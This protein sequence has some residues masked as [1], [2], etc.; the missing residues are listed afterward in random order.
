MEETMKKVVFSALAVL[1]AL[2][3]MSCDIVGTG[4]LTPGAPAGFDGVIYSDGLT[5]S[6]IAPLYWNG[7]NGFD[8]GDYSTDTQSG[9]SAFYVDWSAVADWNGLALNVADTA[10][11]DLSGYDALTFYAKTESG[12][13]TFDKFGIAAGS[14]EE[15][16]LLNQTVTSTWTKYILPLPNPS[17]FN[18]VENIFFTAD[19]AGDKV[20]LDEVK[21]ETLGTLGVTSVANPAGSVNVMLD[22]NAQVNGLTAVFN[23]GV[24]DISNV[25]GVNLSVFFTYSSADE[26]IVTVDDDGLISAVGTTGQSTTITAGLG[27]Q[28]VDITVTIV[29]HFTGLIYDDSPRADFTAAHFGEW[30]YWTFDAAHTES[31]VSVHEGSFAF[32]MQ[33]PETNLA[34][35]PPAYESTGGNFFHYDP[36]VDISSG[37]T[38]VSFAIDLSDGIAKSVDYLQLK[39]GDTSYAEWTANIL[40]STF[41]SNYAVEDLG[42]GFH[43]YTIPL[44][45]MSGF[46]LA[47]FRSIEFWDPKVGGESGTVTHSVYYLDAVKF[48]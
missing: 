9:S 16:F 45:I 43:V 39:L 5:S 41:M 1:L 42:T 34:A 10:L 27:G 17:E 29:D 21:F 30:N 36:G 38:E 2:A 23:D 20:I 47:N 26:G 44:S 4:P 3:V 8:I 18:S 6:V 7:D 33:L 37:Y 14:A 28:T 35:V 31:M 13:Q 46:D 11:V 40:D 12:D 22:G 19:G 48:Q 15:I 24:S 25:S 32:E